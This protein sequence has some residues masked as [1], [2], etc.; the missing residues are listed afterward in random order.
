MIS[1]HCHE[2]LKDLLIGNGMGFT[3]WALVHRQGVEE[4]EER[5]DSFVT[6]FLKTF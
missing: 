6:D 1:F 5:V 2:K 3:V 4:V